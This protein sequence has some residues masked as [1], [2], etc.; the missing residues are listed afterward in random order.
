MK[1][2][3]LA[4]IA[5]LA[6]TA[7]SLPS[8]LRLTDYAPV[9]AHC[10][11]D[12]LSRDAIGLSPQEEA[13]RNER[14]TVAKTALIQWL[15]T[16]NKKFMGDDT[17]FDLTTK[18]WPVLA[19]ASSGGG[20]GSMLNSAG[21]VQAMDARDEKNSESNMRGLYQSM[22]YHSG[23]STGAWLLAAL[24]GNEASTVSQLVAD[25]WI[26]SFAGPAFTPQTDHRLPGTYSQIMLDT[27]AK[28]MAGY[29]PSLVDAWGRVVGL[30]VL[31]GDASETAKTLS[32]LTERADFVGR[33][34][35]YPVFTS[36]HV[37]PRQNLT[38]CNYGTL[39][40]PQIEMHPFEFG[41]WDSGIRSF[42]KTAFMGSQSVA[43]LAP[44]SSTCIQGF[45]NMGMIIGASSNPFNYYCSVIPANNRFSGQLGS[46]YNDLIDMTSI[47]HG[48][49]YLDEFCS[50]PGP[51]AATTHID[52]LYLVDG[53]QGGE[54]LPLW[55]LIAAE[56]DVS[57][58]FA[59]DFSTSTAEYMANGSSLR[60]TYLRSQEM[61]WTRMPFVPAVENFAMHGQNT[62]P[63]FFGC[64]EVDKVLIVYVPNAAYILGTNVPYWQLQIDSVLVDQMVENG[65]LVATMK[66]LDQWPVCVACAIMSK[67]NKETLPS[68]CQACFERFCWRQ[69]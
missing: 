47:V 45:D 35:P 8:L 34:I 13:Y 7:H 22:T 4:A 65:N 21:F 32:G 28:S 39:Q 15:N 55:P 64:D 19:L 44:S 12:G 37:D 1:F 33:Q 66:E 62:Q 61:G 60:Q 49:S 67:V 54:E 9:A 25:R 57:V 58:I 10:P 24:V 46:L 31:V 23:V 40:S 14:S 68:A 53:S 30:H 26:N 16:V 59:P 41:S 42:S 38:G 11:V 63:L 50:V 17:P 52:S 3:T 56:R 2:L 6:P 5:W 48:L 36:L 69:G 51:F 18:D 27:I 29:T 20:V 43:G